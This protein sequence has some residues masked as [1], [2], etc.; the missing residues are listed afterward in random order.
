MLLGVIVPIHSRQAG[1]WTLIV[2]NMIV[3]RT[4]LLSNPYSQ[5]RLHPVYFTWNNQSFCAQY[6]KSTENAVQTSHHRCF[7]GGNVSLT[8]I[9]LSTSVLRRLTSR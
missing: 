5:D 4:A 2:Y 1:E 9:C 6:I 7:H 3:S 8:I